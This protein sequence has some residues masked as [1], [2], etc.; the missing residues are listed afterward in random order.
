VL[1]ALQRTAGVDRHGRGIA[2]GLALLLALPEG[3][4][5]TTAQFGFT[6][7]VSMVA[8]ACT[9]AAAIIESVARH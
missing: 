4:W 1:R 9:W 3:I 6:C 5:G 7:A 8:I 2:I